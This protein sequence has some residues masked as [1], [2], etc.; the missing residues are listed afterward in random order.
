VA[1]QK[2][3]VDAQLLSEEQ[4]QLAKARAE[5]HAD[6][7]KKSMAKREEQ[8]DRLYNDVAGH[9]HERVYAMTVDVFEALAKNDG[10]MPPS[11]QRQLSKIL[12]AVRS[13]NIFDDEVLNKQEADIRLLLAS[14]PVAAS[15][16]G[17]YLPMLERISAQS[18]LAL[19]QLGRRPSR[20]AR[21]FGVDDEPAQ[22]KEM[23]AARAPRKVRVQLKPAPNGMQVAMR[24]PRH[25]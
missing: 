25:Q 1:A 14:R 9:I 2:V 5:M 20:S 13:L 7:E 8:V 21:E 24:E 23:L 11:N 16:P 4:R 19:L 22:L 6:A 3:I 18:R 15:G 17:S 10:A 12:E